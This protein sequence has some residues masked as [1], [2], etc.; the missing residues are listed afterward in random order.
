[1][2]SIEKELLVKMICDARKFSESSRIDVV[3]N[4]F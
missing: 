2:K 4:V 3:D 1:M